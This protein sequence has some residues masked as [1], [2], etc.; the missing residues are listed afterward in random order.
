MSS[1]T[2]PLGVLG[3]HKGLKEFWVIGIIRPREFRAWDVGLT[4]RLWQ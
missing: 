4:A 3:G 2:I 1:Y